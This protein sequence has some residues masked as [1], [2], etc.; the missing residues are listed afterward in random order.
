MDL[1][2]RFDENPILT[3]ERVKPS[4][5][6]AM[7]ECLLNPGI[8][9]Y[10][11]RIGM[12]MRVAERMEQ[13]EGF[14][15]TLVADETQENGVRLVEFA[16]D[17]PKLDYT[18]PRVFTYEGCPYLTTL[19][20]L[21]LAWSEDGISFTAEDS[22]CLNGQGEL[23]TFGIEDCRVTQMEDT[24]YLTYSAVSESGVGV[25]LQTTQDWKSFKHYGMILPPHNKDCTL[26]E[27]KIG[28]QFAAI[29]RPVGA[30]VGG[31][32]MWY[33]TSPDLIHWGSHRC[34]ART[35]VGAWDSQRVGAGA[36]PI[37]TE[38][39]WLEIYHA[40]NEESRYC[41]GAMLLDLKDPSKVIARSDEPIMEPIA[42]YEQE[43]FFG[44]VV[45][46]NGHVIDG[47]TLTL[48]YGAS[49]T[50]ICGATLSIA[51]ILKSLVG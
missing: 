2:K 21:R 22:P 11:G 26:F 42:P 33:S 41:L 37:R 17:D 25:G 3:P 5:Q 28:G 15:S 40:C 9:R 8:F 31:P 1:A 36:A 51:S 39:G 45:F 34:L 35:R 24:Y 44:N 32:F 43:G 38:K 16:L 50:V 6:G 46:T 4:V 12:L 13:R 14:V 20:H 48:Y 23:E 29:H 7:V 10:Q 18:D 30:D 49:D 27:E 47:D 19:S